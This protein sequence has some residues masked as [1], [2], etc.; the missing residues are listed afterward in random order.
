MADFHLPIVPN[1]SSLTRAWERA[2]E[3]RPGGPADGDTSDRALERAAEAA[4]ARLTTDA[5][6]VERCIQD[7]PTARED[8][9]SCALVSAWGAF[10]APGHTAGSAIQW[11][12]TADRRMYFEEAS[13][14]DLRGALANLTHLLSHGLPGA[15]S[16]AARIRITLLAAKLAAPEAP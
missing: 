14:D 8:I 3:R 11:C 5:E 2:Q 7:P 10:S 16:Q 6:L 13:T 4:W 12:I 15:V 9:E 1:L